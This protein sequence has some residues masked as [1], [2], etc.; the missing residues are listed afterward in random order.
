MNRTNTKIKAIATSLKAWKELANRSSALKVAKVTCVRSLLHNTHLQL[1]FTFI[2]VGHRDNIPVER[3]YSH[4]FL[5]ST[6][7]AELPKVRERR[8]I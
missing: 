2:D 5:P 3:I 4:G 6:P 8:R 7:E 1:Q